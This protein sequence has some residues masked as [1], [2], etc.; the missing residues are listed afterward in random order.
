MWSTGMIENGKLVSSSTDSSLTAFNLTSSLTAFD[1]I[2]SSIAVVP[3]PESATD[4]ALGSWLSWDTKSSNPGA[5]G[6]GGGITSGSQSSSSSGLAA[7]LATS[8]AFFLSSQQS[9]YSCSPRTFFQPF[10]ACLSGFLVSAL[11]LSSTNL[12]FS[13]FQHTSLDM[14]SNCP[15]PHF[16][17]SF[18]KSLLLWSSSNWPC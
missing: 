3:I 2:S 11:F 13:P 5:G 8:A 4:S 16:D 7:D 14:Y 6:H 12:L 17:A 9:Q 15:R 18:W 10:P 1:L